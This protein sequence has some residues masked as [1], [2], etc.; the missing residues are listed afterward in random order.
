MCNTIHAYLH[1][2]D[3]KLSGAV[4]TPEGWYAIQRH[5]DKLEKW[6]CVNLMRFNKA[7][8]RVLHLCQ[9][10]P[11]YRYRLGDEGIESSPAEKDLGVLLDEKLDMSRQCALAAQK[12]NRILGCIK[13]SMASRSREVI[14]PLCS[15][16]V[17]PH[18]CPALE[19]SAQERHGAAGAG[20]E[21]GHK[22]DQ[23]DRTPVL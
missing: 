3:T 12:A 2:D 8:C 19:S 7:K 13:R 10:N 16:V 17:R 23:R 6:A 15:A 1:A 18:L 5:L 22:N 11:W 9:D 21:E 14:L 4:D 20:P